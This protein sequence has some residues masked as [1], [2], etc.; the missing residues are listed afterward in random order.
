MGT[1]AISLCSYRL[2]SPGIPVAYYLLFF[3]LDTVLDSLCSSLLLLLPL[4]AQH[5][6]NF[7]LN[8]CFCIRGLAVAVVPHDPPC[9]VPL[10]VF[11][12]LSVIPSD[13]DTRRSRPS[14][15]RSYVVNYSRSFSGISLWSGCFFLLFIKDQSVKENT[16]HIC[17]GG[18][19]RRKKNVSSVYVVITTTFSSSSVTC[20]TQCH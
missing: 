19:N 16:E 5:S 10:L 14:E 9:S 11:I 1:G 2:N 13:R 4:A 17:F 3:I 6:L 20:A 18:S 12:H 8:L 15:F 7:T